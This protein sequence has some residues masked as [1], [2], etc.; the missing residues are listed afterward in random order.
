MYVLGTAND[1]VFEYELSIPWLASSATYS[2]RS[3]SV[4]S[5]ENTP[6]GLR[7]R[8]DGKELFVTGQ[9]Y[10]KVWSYTLSTAWDVSTATLNNSA[11][12]DA[13]NPTGMYM[14][15]D[16][17]RLFVADDAGDYV[18]QYDFNSNGI[19]QIDGNLYI[20]SG[21]I[22]FYNNTAYLATN[23][24]VS[25]ESVFDFT[26]F[27]EI[28]SGN[29]LLSAADRITSYYVPEFGKTSK[30]INQL[31]FGAGYPGN[32]VQ[33]MDFGANSFTLTSDVI[34]F[35]YTGHK[36]TSA[37]IQQVDFVDRGFNLNDPIRIEGMYDNFNFENNATFKVVS[38]SRDEMMLSGQ[39]IESIV[40]LSLGGSISANE[41]DYIT[42]SNSTANARVLNNYTSSTEIAVIQEKQG[43]NELDANVV[44]VNGVATTANVMDVLGSGTGN[45]KISNLYIDDI[46]DSNI[47]SFYTD[48][49][50]GTRPE[51]INIVGGFFLDAYNSHAPEEL[52]PGRMYDTLEMRVFTNTASN[53]ASYGFRVFEPMDS[54]REYYRISA[55]NTTALSAN[56]AIDDI[57]MFV[58]NAAK[59]P[60][61]G[62]GVGGAPG[63]VFINGELIYYYQKYDQDKILTADVWTANTEFDTD[64]LIT[65]NSNVYLVLGNVYA[66]ANAYIDSTSIKQVY[67]NSLSQLR[68]GVDGTGANAHTTDDRVV[69]SSLAQQLPNTAITSTSTLTGEKKVAANVTW[70]VGLNNTISANI[71]DYMTMTSPTANVRILETVANANVV[72]VDF[73]DGNLRIANANVSING[74][75]TTANVTTLNILG[76]VLSTGNV[77]V[78]GKTIKQDYLWKAYGTGDTLDSSTTEWA[79]YIKEERSYTP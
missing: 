37:N 32:K 19:T 63:E 11:D 62:T 15:H 54:D 45:I 3:K 39:P 33:G 60:D 75:T 1:T 22:I 40:T 12:L 56:L 4:A 57:N 58:D 29:V 73:V 55:N 69:D 9:Q 70:R 13:T 26:R 43:W 64:S 16:G 65:F 34:G 36:I 31:M 61:P 30:D 35:N 21:N 42:Q 52:I 66:N 77:S 28:N 76:E 44:S 49:A 27:T 71:G 51:D 48:T 53:T 14:R 10:N 24:N 38:I 50:L 46:L 79:E 5:E 41:G 47:A 59:L 23:A 17:T 78:T 2:T 20:T 72:A 74:T 67:L 68:R 8:E 18:Q 7:F 6:T 25:S